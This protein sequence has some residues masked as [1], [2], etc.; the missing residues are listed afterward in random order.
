M[1]GNQG[2]IG[3]ELPE[4]VSLRCG[5]LETLKEA[6]IRDR[7]S[8]K[9]GPSITTADADSRSSCEIARLWSDATPGTPGANGL[10]GQTAGKRFSEVVK[11]F[12]EDSFGL[13]RAF[14]PGDWRF[15]VE[16]QIAD[17]AQYAHL[18]T[19][20]DLAKS[21]DEL[22]VVLGQDYLVRPDVVVYRAPLQIEQAGKECFRSRDWSSPLL[23]ID[24]SFP[25]M[26]ASISCKLTIR[27]DRAQNTRTEAANLIRNRRGAL[28]HVVAVT[29]E[30][31]P[32]RIASLALGSSDIDC[33][34]HA[35]LDELTRV[36]VVVSE[37]QMDMLRMLVESR[38]LRDIA[39]L[40]FDLLA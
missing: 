39:D 19:L 13:L 32:T 7:Q 30:P 16:Q 14:R 15:G 4:V 21:S 12:V 33:V 9:Y 25:L 3:K 35:G 10:S 11:S 1:N 36:A 31:L 28:P 20:E 22:R 38:R 23:P 2:S 8:E 40:P 29:A 27:S 6:V 17:F 26:H 5:F 34:Y 37:D 24:D 18:R